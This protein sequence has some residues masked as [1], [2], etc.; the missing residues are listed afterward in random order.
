MT[1]PMIGRLLGHTQV[2]TTHRYAHL[3][4]GPLRVGLNQV[5][6]LLRPKLKLIEM[7]PPGPRPNVPESEMAG[8]QLVTP[9]AG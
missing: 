8:G 2:Q 1:L 5:G 6:E 9:L 4:D 3:F 7:S